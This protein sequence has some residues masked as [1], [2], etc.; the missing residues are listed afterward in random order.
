MESG[1]TEHME[2]EVPMNRQFFVLLAILSGLLATTNLLGSIDVILMS[3]FI[4]VIVVIGLGLCVAVGFGMICT[5]GHYS[6]PL[7]KMLP[8]TE[9]ERSWLP[10]LTVEQYNQLD[11][12]GKQAYRDNIYDVTRLAP[13]AQLASLREHAARRCRS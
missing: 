8:L 13:D 11:E 2:G 4:G 6:E 7:G 5:Q 9:E 12:E 1:K 10:D 3:A